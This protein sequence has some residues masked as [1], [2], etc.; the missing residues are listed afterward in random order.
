MFAYRY[1][2]YAYFRQCLAARTE[3]A[4]GRS[5]QVQHPA[6]GIEPGKGAD[7]TEKQILN[8]MLQRERMRA[9]ATI[10]DPPA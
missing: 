9:N 10:P 3:P 2:G 4:P 1:V 7:D 6:F 5:S 8:Y